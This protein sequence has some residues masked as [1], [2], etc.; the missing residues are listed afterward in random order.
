MFSPFN[1]GTFTTKSSSS[2]FPSAHSGASAS[3]SVSASSSGA[4]LVCAIDEFHLVGL[5]LAALA[6]TGMELEPACKGVI[7]LHV[8]T[9][10]CTYIY[11]YIYIYICI[12]RAKQLYVHIYLCM[13][14]CRCIYFSIILF[15]KFIYSTCS[16]LAG[17]EI[18][19]S[20]STCRSCPGQVQRRAL[21]ERQVFPA[22]ASRKVF[23]AEEG[24]RYHLLHGGDLFSFEA[25]VGGWRVGV[26]VGG[27]IVLQEG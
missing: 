4:G 3:D 17:N 19:S 23:G 20:N 2:S 1:A 11:I 8:I 21:W 5:S 22:R 27:N 15:Y 26:G 10:R 7:N 9:R 14:W 6:G 16:S 18:L 25:Q 12:H 13:I 24:D